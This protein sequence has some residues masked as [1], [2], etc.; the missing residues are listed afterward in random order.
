MGNSFGKSLV[1]TTF[2]ESHG[3][4]VGGILDGFPPKIE[5]NPDFLQTEINR[6]RTGNDFFSSSRK[7]EDTLEILSGIFEG[8][9]TGAPI[10]FLVYNHDQKPADYEHLK[11]VYRPSHADFTYQQKYGIR[12]P[13]GGGR[14]SARETLARVAAGAFAKLFL[15]KDQISISSGIAQIGPY[16]V[17]DPGSGN[18]EPLAGFLS[19]EILDFL[20]LLKTSGNTAGGVVSC[21][22]K[23]VPAGLGE[24]VFDKLQADL[25]KAM[26]S[27][28]AVKGFEYGSGFA[29]A[30][31]T[32]SEHND[33][34]TMNNGKIETKTNHSGGI[35]GGISNGMDI[36][37]RVA[38]KPVSTLMKDQESITVSGEPTVIHGKGRHDVCVV[39]RAL[40]VVEAMAALVVADHLL[41]MQA[42]AAKGSETIRGPR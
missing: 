2:G 7:E 37:F 9:S 29:G 41:R 5:I 18:A 39:P 36:T 10:A 33:I 12:D 21:C 28:N 17:D 26:L 32:G 3:L 42:L 31:M 8:L 14:S 23:G 6:R 11:N 38:F 22:I 25:A 13:R 4:A 24:P 1:L 15:Q 30:A 20:Q 40:P 35:Q 19:K 27:I 34:F 16:V